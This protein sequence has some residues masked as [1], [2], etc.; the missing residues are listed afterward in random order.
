MSCADD[1]SVGVASSS[2]FIGSSYNCSSQ[3]LSSGLAVDGSIRMRILE[4]A[5]SLST[6]KASY[7]QNALR[8]GN[9]PGSVLA[10][11]RSSLVSIG[12]QFTRGSAGTA[13]PPASRGMLKNDRG[14]G[15]KA[16]AATYTTS[17][18]TATLNPD[19][20]LLGLVGYR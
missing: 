10:I 3:H 11:S 13:I 12:G 8:S 17:N 1:T 6:P 2:C 15:L 4:Q 18:G 19:G 9:A 16:I 20:E 5:G 7:R 14:T